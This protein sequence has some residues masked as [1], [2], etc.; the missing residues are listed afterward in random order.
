MSY[1][2]APCDKHLK[3]S[4]VVP[5]TVS[6]LYVTLYNDGHTQCHHYTP[7]CTVMVTDHHCTEWCMVMTLC[8]TVIVQSGL[9][10]WHYDQ[11]SPTVSSPYTTLY[12]DYYTITC[13]ISN[14]FNYKWSHGRWGHS[15][16][17][18]NTYYNLTNVQ[19]TAATTSYVIL[20]PKH[21]NGL[22]FHFLCGH[23]KITFWTIQSGCSY[24][25]LSSELGSSEC[26]ELHIT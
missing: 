20:L 21:C 7:L 6:S 5:H 11:Q 18:Y 19:R 3:L 2:Y 17:N 25:R 8:L 4:L 16:W 22:L 13:E 1:S 12:N 14:V 15:K 10:W 26:E 23:H 24:M 9:W